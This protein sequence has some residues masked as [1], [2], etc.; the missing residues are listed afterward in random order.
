[1]T[2]TAT[3]TSAGGTPTGMV[4]FL[5]GGTMLGT[6][7]LNGSG[8]A[9]LNTSSLSVGSHSLSAFYEGD[10]NSVPSSSA[11]SDQTV[12][13]LPTP[14]I[15]GPISVCAGSGVTLD[16]GV[17][18]SAY[19]WSPGGET[20]Q[21]ITA[22]PTVMTGYSVTVTTG[23]GC[24]GTSA[25]HVVT[26]RTAPAV[27]RDPDPWTICPGRTALLKAICSDSATLHYQWFKGSA[28]DTPTPVGTD[29]PLYP[30]PADPP[31][32]HYWYRVTNDCATVDSAAT[33]VAVTP[34]CPAVVGFNN[35]GITDF[36]WRNTITGDLSVWFVG[37]GGYDGDTSPGTV[38]PS[39]KII[40]LANVDANHC[41]DI[42]W[43]NDDG[44]MM[45]LWFITGGA[46]TGSGF[47]G[48]IGNTDWKVVG[49]ADFNGDRK[50]DILWRYWPTGAMS[51][52]F[53]DETGYT[54]AISPG[55]VDPSWQILNH[56][57]F[58]GGV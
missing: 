26:V 50:H 27:L 55:A 22:S 15:S 33:P 19:L 45:S 46:F 12:D 58:A 51:I 3:V 29:S 38:D 10:A 20:T 31:L 34:E 11:A 57:V 39:W 35:D 2:L 40:G 14:S 24:P 47:V 16:A 13:P 56:V 21:A 41:A 17:G 36:L 42:F 52:W 6:G 8:T 4:S 7:A 53:V 48:G 23:A 28:G 44:G 49:V 54:G 37:P 43:R 9:T 5:D 18:Y 1:M 30:A 25:T 32:A